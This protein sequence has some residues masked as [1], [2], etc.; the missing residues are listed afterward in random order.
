[1]EVGAGVAL[2]HRACYGGGVAA[3]AFDA[4]TGC[5]REVGVVAWGYAQA[6]KLRHQFSLRVA[7]EYSRRWH[8]HRGKRL[9]PFQLHTKGFEGMLVPRVPLKVNRDV[10]STQVDLHACTLTCIGGRG[11]TALVTQGHSTDWIIGGEGH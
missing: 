10:R 6:V 8:A 4:R 11:L 3:V 9:R 2:H 5:L 7:S 1:M